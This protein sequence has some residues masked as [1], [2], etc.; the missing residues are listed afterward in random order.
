[1]HSGG[2]DA[3]AGGGHGPS[4]AV[5]SPPTT[6][7]VKIEDRL[8]ALLRSSGPSSGFSSDEYLN[9]ALSEDL[10]SADVPE[11]GLEDEEE[12]VQRR[13]AQL[14]LRLQMTTQSCHDEIGRIGAELRAILPRCAADVG[15]VGTGLGGM[16]DDAAALLA[17]PRGREGFEEGKK[18]GALAE[19]KGEKPPAPVPSDQPPPLPPPSSLETLATLHALR[20][21]LSLTRSILSAASS[22]DATLSSVPALLG[23]QNLTEAVSALSRLESGE[24]ALRGMPGRS[25]RRSAIGKIRGQIEVLLKPQLLHALQRMD[26]RLGPL[27]KVAGMYARLGKTDGLTEEYVRQRPGRV[28]RAWFDW[29]QVTTFSSSAASESNYSA[30]AERRKGDRP[31]DLEF[32]GE[33]KEEEW[34]EE[35]DENYDEAAASE[36]QDLLPPAPSVA[37]TVPAPQSDFVA[38]IPEWYDKVLTL[39]SEERRRSAAVFGTDLAPEIVARVSIYNP[40]IL[41]VGLPALVSRPLPC[42][43]LLLCAVDSLIFETGD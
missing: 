18:D 42:Q 33:E 16:R 4:A 26:T 6:S 9:L 19:G 3:E 24:R 25:D 38:W 12:A 17:L 29:A 27:Q 21:N 41:E 28:H 20:S 32:M 34:L 37:V 43:S 36:E 10:T 40:Q 1:M 5:E 8:S 31:E 15:R 35:Q 39:L 13:M 11:D 14:A 22:W 7:S 2:G 23:S 30:Q